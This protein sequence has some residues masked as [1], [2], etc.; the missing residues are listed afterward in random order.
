MKVRIFLLVCLIVAL[1]VFIVT[2]LKL[3][4]ANTELGVANERLADQEA[5]IRSLEQVRTTMAAL[6]LPSSRLGPGMRT[7]YHWNVS[8]PSAGDVDWNAIAFQLTGSIHA[9]GPSVMWIGA[10]D[11]ANDGVYLT[12]LGKNRVLFIKLESLK[13]YNGSVMVPGKWLISHTENAAYLVFVTT[14]K[15]VVTRDANEVYEV[16]GD[17][18]YG[19]FPGDVIF[20]SV[21]GLSTVTLS[22]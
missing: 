8:A 4:A 11:P 14:S 19:E 10:A 6:P 1:S 22:R 21:P 16:S 2:G 18:L 3:K 17:L 7:L 20:I 12:D 15:Q 9:G 13:V 5:Q